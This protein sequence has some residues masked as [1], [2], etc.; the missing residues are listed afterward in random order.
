M[1]LNGNPYA[2]R[3]R[4][5]ESHKLV[6]ATLALAFEQ[7]TQKMTELFNIES[8]LECEGIGDDDM[9]ERQREVYNQIRTRLGLEES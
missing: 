8:W 5:A 7:R 6:E 1:T 9:T 4:T 2:D 3:A